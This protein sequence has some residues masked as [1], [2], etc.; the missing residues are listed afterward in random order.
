M[1][2][3]TSKN[4]NKAPYSIHFVGRKEME[5]DIGGRNRREL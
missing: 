3:W 5:K 4:Q 2:S 1:K